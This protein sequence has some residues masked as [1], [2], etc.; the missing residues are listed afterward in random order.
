MKYNVS[1]I[2]EYLD[3][4]PTERKEPLLTIMSM[5]KKVAPKV[6]EEYSHNMPFYTLNGPLFALA[7][8]KHYMALYVTEADLVEKYKPNLGKTNTSKSCI[9]FKKLENLNLEAVEQLLAASYERRL[10]QA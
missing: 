9:R 4:I 3:A 5:I 7:S 1:N 6:T 8:Q 10:K 2:Q